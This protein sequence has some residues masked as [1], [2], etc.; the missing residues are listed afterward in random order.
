[1]APDAISQ[2][3]HEINYDKAIPLDV[4]SLAEGGVATAYDSL[5]PVL[6]QFI[7]NPAKIIEELDNDIP[8]YVVR[9]SE[10][11]FRIYAPDLD[12]EDKHSWARATLALFSIV[13]EQLMHATHRFYAIN[14][15]NDLFG[16][17]LTPDEAALA[18]KSVP[19]KR[20]WPYL[21]SDE[22]PWFGQYH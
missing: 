10:S 7:T 21:P 1:M 20:D 12:E 4:E 14:G 19:D 3:T 5:L 17:F 2:M 22:T 8:S 6:C 13:N 16:M 15:G 18:Q 11:T 9:A